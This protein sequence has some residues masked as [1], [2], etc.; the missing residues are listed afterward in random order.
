MDIFSVVFQDFKLMPFTLGENVAVGL[1]FD[2]ELVIENLEKTGFGDR[3]KTMSKGL[4]TYLMKNFEEAGVE[5]SGGE[6]QKIALARAL[7]KNSPFIV[8]DEPTAALD[9]VAEY[10]IY[11]KFN[12]IVGDKTAIYISHRLSSCR[13]CDDIIV[14]DN[15]ELIQ[16]GKHE[17]LVLNNGGKYYE[18]W[19]AQAQ[20]YQ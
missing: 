5:V 2:E 12:E 19:T 7:Y 1:S 14:F 4:N 10:E 15:G 16:R 20:Y 11:S 6:A 3:L 9:P 13:F 18:L 17:E 8:L